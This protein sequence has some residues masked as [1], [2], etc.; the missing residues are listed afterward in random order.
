[1]SSGLMSENGSSGLDST[2]KRLWP[3]FSIGTEER[4]LTKLRSGNLAAMHID[5]IIDEAEQLLT[6]TLSPGS[7]AI[8]C[9]SGTDA[10]LSAYFALNLD[11]DAEVLVPTNTF[12]ATVTPM[13]LLGLRP[14]LCDST[15]YSGGIDLVDA[16]RRVTSKTQAIVVT[17]LWGHPVDMHAVMALAR[18]FSLRV[19]EDCSHAHGACWQ[20]RSVGTFGDAAIYSLGTTKMVSGGKAGV[21]FTS[22]TEI[23][24]RAL[25]FGQPKHRATA[26]LNDASLKPFTESGFG[27]NLRGSPLAAI[28]VI[29]H[30]Q[31]LQ[32]TIAI[33]NKNLA[34]FEAVMSPALPELVCPKR[35]ERWT[36]GTWYKYQTRWVDS[37]LSRDTLVMTLR[38]AGM[39]VSKP[40]KGLHHL[41]LFQYPEILQGRPLGTAPLCDPRA[42]LV[43]DALLEE[44]VTWDTR[45]LYDEDNDVVNRYAEMF[46]IVASQLDPRRAVVM[47]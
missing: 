10:L 22:D 1:M 36:H 33:K 21:L 43:T 14:V 12:R 6:S 18:K 24:D 34:K 46:T 31:R 38:S 19:L 4:V 5:P 47:K 28:L 44:L 11:A 16:E 2:A 25:I 15:P 35:D 7:R 27:V 40:E 23:Y 37:V 39:R 30:L 13:M 3:F 32:E 26:H 41:P 20:G 8:F 45:D 29:D 17:H 9:G 42:Y